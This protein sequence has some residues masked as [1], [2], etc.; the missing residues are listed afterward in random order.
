MKTSPETKLIRTLL[1][2]LQNGKLVPNPGFQRNLVWSNKDK[3]NFID[4]VLQGLPF[5]EI[6]IAASEVDLKT[7]QG[8]EMLVDGQQRITTLQQYFTAS[9]SLK[10]A[11]PICAYSDLSPDQQRNFLNY[12]VAV[13]NLGIISPE[14]IKKVFLK[15]NATSYSVNAMETH[16]A[17]F[18]GP[19]KQCA[20]EFAEDDF[21][22]TH[23][24][25]SAREIRRMDDVV[26]TLTIIISMLSNYFNRKDELETYLERFNDEFPET[27]D[28]KLRF[29]STKKFIETCKFSV[30]SRAWKKTDFLVLFIELDRLINK[31]NIVLD[32][33]KVSAAVESF[34]D[35]V[36]QELENTS[37]D[38]DLQTYFKTTVQATNDR[39]SRVNRAR[40][41]RKIILAA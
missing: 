19:L 30:R 20:D 33:T 27:A 25:F 38:E 2:E 26:Y 15:I 40:V 16:N 5:P 24:M 29:N 3:I 6:Y 4:T 7:A 41:I 21:F 35:R 32:T 36:N 39:T 31:E 34:Y 14:E 23:K 11:P 28:I 22:D 37:G 9:K 18:R 8:F 13:R 10:V 17:R 1:N 12:D